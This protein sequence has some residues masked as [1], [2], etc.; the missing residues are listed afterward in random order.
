[1]LE[2]MKWSFY[3]YSILLL[4][5]TMLVGLIFGAMFFGVMFAGGKHGPPDEAKMVGGIL[6][7]V[8]G[9]VLLFLLVKTVLLFFAGRYVGER[10]HYT[11]I[12][13]V[14]IISMINIPIGTA[15]GVFTVIMLSKDS[16]KRRFGVPAGTR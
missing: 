12:F 11:F 14:A 7:A 10:S 8:F 5:T 4:M 15:L 1:M 16:M 9:L 3:A 13:V 2:L 6:G